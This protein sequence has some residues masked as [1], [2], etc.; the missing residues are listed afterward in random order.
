MKSFIFISLIT[1]FLSKIVPNDELEEKYFQ[2]ISYLIKLAHENK[3]ISKPE[4]ILDEEINY[5]KIRLDTSSTQKIDD[6][7][8]EKYNLP[9]S[10]K[11]VFQ[12]IYIDND[13]DEI[14]HKI[15]GL[16]KGII[17][18]NPTIYYLIHS[19]YKY[20][21]PNPYKIDC[22][23]FT[24]F[25][26]K[27]EV[28]FESNMKTICNKGFMIDSCKNVEILEYHSYLN[29]KDLNEMKNYMVYKSEELYSLYLDE[30]YPTKKN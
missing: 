21:Q 7:F 19:H 1:I 4:Y 15:E 28:K 5:A 8:I 30:I 22:S 13:S 29:D 3:T 26:F 18:F 11:S 2:N 23:V 20:S 12:E 24:T 14:Y 9:K 25:K 6:A 27:L 16:K 17:S 10:L